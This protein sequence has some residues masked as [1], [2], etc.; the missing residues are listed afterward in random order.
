[1]AKTILIT[2]G[3]SGIGRAVTEAV[4]AE[5]W[6]AIAVDVSQA[7]LDRCREELSAAGNRLVVRPLNVT[8]DAAVTALVDALEAEG[9]ALDGVVNSAGIAKEID[10]FNTS[11]DLFRTIL[12]VNVV[13]GFAVARAAARHMMARK[14]GAIVNIASV[15]GMV[16]SSGRVAYGASK[17]AVLT[18]TRVLAIEWAK[19]GIRVNTISPG[20]IE[21]PMVAAMHTPES[22]AAYNE[23]VPMERYGTPA[24]IAAAA[25]FLLDGAKSGYIT[26]QN[27]PVDGG[28]TIAGVLH[29][30]KPGAH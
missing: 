7:T 13:G 24:E 23:R 19:Y 25:M 29:G 22:R 5:G 14:A 26:G 28:M 1:M 20:P 17:G 18:M 3:P 9:H 10:A 2:G 30:N 21:T 15:S 11:T 8:D 4:L 6:T 12:D 16:G 27:I